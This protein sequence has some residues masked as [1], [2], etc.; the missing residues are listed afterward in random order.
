M[1]RLT[2]SEVETIRRD[3][4]ASVEVKVIA[5][6]LGRSHGVIRQKVQALGL[7]RNSGVTRALRYAPEELKARRAEMTDAEFTAAAKAW[8]RNRVIRARNARDKHISAEVEAIAEAGGPRKAQM[9]SMRDAGATLESIGKRF[10][11]TRERVRQITDPDFQE[12]VRMMRERRLALNGAPIVTILRH[13]NRMT[14]NH[15][16]AFLKA[17]GAQ[18]EEPIW[19]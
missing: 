7:H 10:G 19:S 1:K 6:K 16:K 13:W 5:R 3:Y 9:R 15:Q 2:P 14:P 18:I 4:L 17:I 12:R 11:I 8:K